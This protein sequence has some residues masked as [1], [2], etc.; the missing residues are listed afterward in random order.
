MTFGFDENLKPFSH[1]FSLHLVFQEH[2][3]PKLEAS[4]F[5]HTG[6]ILRGG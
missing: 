5:S 6:N 4:A 3:F 1:V 2:I